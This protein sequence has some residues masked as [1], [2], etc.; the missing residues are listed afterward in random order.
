MIPGVGKVIGN[1]NT[2]GKQGN[3]VV[4]R[5]GVAGESAQQIKPPAA[6]PG[7]NAT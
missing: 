6:K 4:L 7:A 5:N 1:V 3:F 2:T